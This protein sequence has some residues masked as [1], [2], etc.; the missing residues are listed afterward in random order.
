[1]EAIFEV[2]LAFGDEFRRIELN[3]ERV[4]GPV[5]KV[6]LVFTVG[7]LAEG[8]L[9]DRVETIVDLSG[10]SIEH[11]RLLG[12]SPLAGCIAACGVASV[13][14][15]LVECYDRAPAKVIACLKAKGR[16]IGADVVKCLIG[17][18]GGA[19]AGGEATAV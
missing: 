14:G 2:T 8:G 3:A 10:Q 11:T 12:L 18:A 16:S 5:P 15:P 9:V 19:V 4:A 13:V 17:C 7:P 1:M 6:R